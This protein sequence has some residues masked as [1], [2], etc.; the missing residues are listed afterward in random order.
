MPILS[1]PAFG[2]RTAIIYITVGA[3]ID[4]WTV[5]WYLAFARGEVMT[6]N[7]QFWLWGFFLSGLTLVIVGVLLGHIG[8][9]ARRAELPPPETTPVEAQIQ[10]TAAAHPSPM[11]AASVGTNVIPGTRATTPA[12]ATV[13]ATPSV[14]SAPA[15]TVQQAARENY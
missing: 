8:R 12:G 5:V 15:Q 10:T 3:L 9:A 6:R 4:V 1:K 14:G 13:P 7:T 11:V 2:P